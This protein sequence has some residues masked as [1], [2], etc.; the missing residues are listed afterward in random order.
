MKPINLS[1]IIPND[2]SLP[3]CACGCGDEVTSSNAHHY[4]M[5][6]RA[7]RIAHTDVRVCASAECLEAYA[8]SGAENDPPPA[9]HAA[10]VEWTDKDGN[11][12]VSPPSVA[13]RCNNCC[14]V[15]ADNDSECFTFHKAPSVENPQG[16]Y[17]HDAAVCK[18]EY[19][20]SA[21]EINVTPW[22]VHSDNPEHAHLHDGE[23]E[24]HILESKPGEHFRA[25]IDPEQGLIVRH[26]H[27][28]KESYIVAHAA[29]L[30]EWSATSVD[31][32]THLTT[33]ETFVA[34]REGIAHDLVPTVVAERVRAL[35]ELRE[36]E[37]Q[38]RDSLVVDM[39]KTDVSNLTR[40]IAA[41]NSTNLTTNRASN[42]W[43]PILA[44]A[45]LAALLAA[46]ATLLILWV[47]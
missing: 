27:H 42:L 39:A 40:A 12:K 26:P 7:G 36:K 19:C 41:G 23:L 13:R 11:L 18:C 16:V 34:V 37:A 22:L 24:L 44:S 17:D 5:M 14:A 8:M 6:I 1:D 46:G 28:L 38:E 9:P 43:L 4:V 33:R 30:N 29:A 2:P 21:G 15:R 20:W 3:T 47:K 25:S 45:S 31:T 32:E 35:L 10:P